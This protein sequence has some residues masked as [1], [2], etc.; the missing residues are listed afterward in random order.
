MS[1]DTS[2]KLLFLGKM[3]QIIFHK[4]FYTYIPKKKVHDAYSR[5]IKKTSEDD[6]SRCSTW[7]YCTVHRSGRSNCSAIPPQG[8]AGIDSAISH[9]QDTRDRIT[10]NTHIPPDVT[11]SN[12][13]TFVCSTTTSS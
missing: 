2:K 10:A 8:Q 7:S 5:F 6:C 9:I 12:R 13:C 3:L 4:G 1:K 11:D